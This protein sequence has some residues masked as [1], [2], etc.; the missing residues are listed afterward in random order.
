[1]CGDPAQRLAQGRRRVGLGVDLEADM[2]VAD[3]H[4]AEIAGRRQGLAAAEADRRAARRRSPST[5]TP[6]PAQAMHF[7]TRRRV[8]PCAHRQPRPS[9]PRVAHDRPPV[10]A[11]TVE[12]GAGGGLFAAR[13]KFS[14]E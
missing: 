11:S 5:A 12:I 10:M 8:A 1:M 13:R 3:L 9:H 2:A 7:S 14:R 6:A 4:E